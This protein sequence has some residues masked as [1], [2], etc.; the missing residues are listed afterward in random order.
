ML[1]VQRERNLMAFNFWRSA[2]IP[3]FLAACFGGVTCFPA[4]TTRAEDK[5]SKTGQS[6]DAAKVD[7]ARREAIDFLRTTQLPDGAWTQETAPGVSGL[8]S[9]ALLRA[10]VSPRD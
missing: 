5:S 2:V 4:A 7:A 1:F 3:A 8:I 6:I 10:G 9:W